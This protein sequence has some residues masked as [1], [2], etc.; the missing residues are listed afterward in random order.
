MATGLKWQSCRG[1]ML[2]SA[3]EAGESLKHYIFADGGGVYFWKARYRPEPWE[4]TDAASMVAWLD[5]LTS[6]IHGRST[7]S[8]I[9]HVLQIPSVEIR[10]GGLNQE[11]HQ[12][13]SQFLKSALARKWLA[14]YIESL[15]KFAPTLYVGETGNLRRRAAEHVRHL[16][17]FGLYVQEASDLSWEFLDFYYLAL[18]NFEQ[19]PE[20]LRKSIEYVSAALTIAGLTKRPG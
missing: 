5:R 10:G 6:G 13:L 15:E 11:K 19:K 2:Q 16:T 20:K 3:V 14:E 1:S 9:S 18:N 12:Y 17:D 8:T 7:T 4:S